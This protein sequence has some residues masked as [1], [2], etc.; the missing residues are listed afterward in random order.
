M[1]KTKK[2]VATWLEREGTT[3]EYRAGK[4]TSKMG[5]RVVCIQWSDTQMLHMRLVKG[6]G[7]TKDFVI[8]DEQNIKDG[9]EKD[10]DRLATYWLD[11]NGTSTVIEVA[12]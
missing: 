5:K 7:R 1:T 10:A 2:V 3:W 4:G 8:Y 9:T 6:D 12:R 11:P